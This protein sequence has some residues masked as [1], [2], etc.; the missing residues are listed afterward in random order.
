MKI[1]ISGS[2]GLVGTALGKSLGRKGHEVFSLVR[3][4]PETPAEVEWYPERGSLA[5]SRLEGMDAVVHLAGE[6]IAEGRWGDEKK[7]RIRESR[8]KGTTVLSEALGNL[9]HPPK[10]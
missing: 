7:K 10:T 9:K 6:S 4:A 2:H 1:L 5:L 3:H 8:V